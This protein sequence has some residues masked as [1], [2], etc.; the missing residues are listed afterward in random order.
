M[1]NLVASRN[2]HSTRTHELEHTITQSQKSTALAVAIVVLAVVLALSGGANEF[3]EQQQVKRNP[4][5]IEEP[6]SQLIFFAVT[7]GLYIDGLSNETVELII[8]P[9]EMSDYER[10]RKHF[11]YACPLCHPAYEAFKLYH[12]RQDFYGIKP[13]DINTFGKGL[14]PALVAQ[15]Q[16][17]QRSVR[18]KAVETLIKKWV[19]RRIEK[20]RLSD[21]ERFTLT[22]L[23]EEGRKQGMARLEK[24]IN[25]P[26]AKHDPTWKA[27]AVCDGSFGACKMNPKKDR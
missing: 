26:N 18:L 15:L 25:D 16:S 24:Q 20:M 23:I 2:F 4:H 12:Q 8:G 3:A 10:Y 6:S 17:R 9:Q 7:E 14:D 5:W 27:C 13:G 21:Q 19:N 1:V 11:I 22:R